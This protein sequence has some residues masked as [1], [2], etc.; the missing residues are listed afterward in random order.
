MAVH[1]EQLCK[2]VPGTHRDDPQRGRRSLPQHPVRHIVH[3]A[4]A[5]NCHDALG[6]TLH[7]LLGEQGA[8]SGTIGVL[9]IHRPALRPEGTARSA[10]GPAP[11]RGVHD[12]VR[13]DQSLQ[14]RKSA[15]VAPIGV[16]ANATEGS[17]GMG[18]PAGMGVTAAR[19]GAGV[20]RRCGTAP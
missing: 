8:V 12:D 2:V 11:G 7:C 5:A 19:V 15:Q 3:G 18:V 10:R 20:G 4:I 9:E 6:T 16:R 13:V 1:A 14:Y 17:A